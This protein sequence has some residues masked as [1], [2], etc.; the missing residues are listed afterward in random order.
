MK[1]SARTTFI[2]GIVSFVVQ[3]IL[4]GGVHLTSL[5]PADWV[6]YATGWM[7]LISLTC[8]AVLTAGSG[9]SSVGPGPLAPPPTIAEAN[10][11][12]V[13]AQTGSK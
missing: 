11:L 4:Q 8:T 5:I 12:M 10:K 9:F 1:L 13:Q 7:A 2:I 3:G 6:P